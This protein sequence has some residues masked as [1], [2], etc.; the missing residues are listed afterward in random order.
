MI[1]TKSLRRW[2]IA[3]VRI[4][5]RKFIRGSGRIVILFS[6]LGF[7]IVSVLVALQWRPAKVIAKNQRSL[8]DGIERR[9]PARIQRLL[10]KDYSD[11]WGFKGEDLVE[12]MTDAGSQFLALVVTP[13]DETIVIAEGRATVTAKLMISGKPVG[14]AGL[15][16]TRQVNLL[17]EP[18]VF[19]W[20]KQSF[21]PNSWRLVR[22]DNPALPDDLYGYEP[23]DIRRAMKGE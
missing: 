6:I 7:L 4:S 16:V 11:R 14:P 21:L 5:Q 22:V 18:F 3:G 13:E 17:K 19:T 23:G 9:S 10:S 20:E 15:E 1:F 8:I 12:T 2:K